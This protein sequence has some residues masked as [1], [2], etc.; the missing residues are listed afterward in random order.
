MIILFLRLQTLLKLS[1]AAV[2]ANSEL[3]HLLISLHAL[4]QVDIEALALLRLPHERSCVV[5]QIDEKL[6]LAIDALS[7]QVGILLVL[8]LKFL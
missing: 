2:Q 8:F 4:K 3:G 6:L 5:F 7:H 1:L